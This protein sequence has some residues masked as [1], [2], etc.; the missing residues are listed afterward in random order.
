MGY[1]HDNKMAQFI[2]PFLFQGATG[3][4][5]IAAGAVT[6]TWAFH[7]AAAASTGVISIPI[8][9][10]SNSGNLKGSL[11]KSIEVDYELLIA[12]ATSITAALAK[13]TRGAEGAVAVVSAVTVTQD[14]AAA[15]AAAT[16]DQHKLTVTLTT[17]EWIDNDAY[18]IL[19]LTCVCGAAVT[20]DVLA[21]VANYTF[22]A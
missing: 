11:L 18:Y 16:Q 21:A 4:Y 22:K 2:P 20:I 8:I 12:G 13:V 19:N 3:T 7:R 14:L 1:V 15:V 5:T 10:P 9:L 17:P 6:G